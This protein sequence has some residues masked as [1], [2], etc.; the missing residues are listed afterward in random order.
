L[1]R[2]IAPIAPFVHAPTCAAAYEA[3]KRHAE[4]AGFI[5]D[6]A[7]PDGSGL[8]VLTHIRKTALD[9]PCAVITALTGAAIPREANRFNARYLPKPMSPIDLRGFLLDAIEYELRRRVE[10]T[11]RGLR[12][13][14]DHR[15]LAP[16]EAATLAIK[17]L[18]LPRKE[19][20][21]ALGIEPAT[22]KTIE[23]RVR[24][25]LC[26]RTVEDAREMV[27]SEAQP[28]KSAGGRKP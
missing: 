22:L 24:R 4:W 15:G 8:D 27:R 7:L 1:G 19:Q 14:A 28:R 9:A 26:A 5:V 18:N 13:T 20:L 2:W 23:R 10:D 17:I 12:R 11:A 21:D 3:L 16:K 25:K 6:V